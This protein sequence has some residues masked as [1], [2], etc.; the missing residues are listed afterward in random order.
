MQRLP[1]LDLLRS[2]AIVWVML[3]HSYIVGGV[4]EH[5]SWLSNYGWMG[6]DLFFV[7]SGYLIGYQ[8]LAPLARGEP[9]AWR[10]FYRRRAFRI[11]PAFL[12]VLA[13]YVAIPTL[14]E[15]PGLQPAW[16]FLSFTLN[17]L[18]DY[19]HNQ[20]FS[21][22]WSLCVEEHFYLLFPWLAFWMTRRPS[23]HR[24]VALGLAVVAFG[25]IVRGYVWLHDMAPV[26][27]QDGP[28]FGLRFVE[29]I[30]YPT[31]ARLDGL[32]AG[33][34][35]AAL[36]IGRP[37][38]WRRWQARRSLLLVAGI[39]VFA[40]ALWLFHDRLGFWPSVLGYPLL[41]IALALCVAS[42]TAWPAHWSIPGAGWLAR[43]SYSLYLSH[44]LALHAVATWVVGP[45]HVHGMAAFA[46]YAAGVLSVGA[47]LHYAVERPFLRWRERIDTRQPIGA[48]RASITS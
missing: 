46:L 7:L 45:W 48:A 41:S 29:G 40:L 6:V 43:T 1:G 22:A 25:M 24:M 42:A 13:I 5:F 32:L 44:K 8:L 3:F 17:L 14:R 47:A 10:D 30:Y 23:T 11:L 34:A 12:V 21:H 26:R 16:Q 33:V 36:R 9:L 37:Q 4:G 19:Q 28:A 15:A 39:A 27:D 35:L 20:A 18:I 31:W 38:L 2:W